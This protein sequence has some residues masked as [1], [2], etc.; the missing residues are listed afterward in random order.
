MRNPSPSAGN[1]PI[2]PVP[3]LS[4]RPSNDEHELVTLVESA[5]AGDPDAWTRLVQRFD[6]M[7]RQIA[8]SYRLAP[9]DVDDVVQTTWLNL[10]EAIERIREPTAIAGWLATATRRGA[11]RRKQAYVREQPTD[12]PELGDRP[13]DNQPETSLLERERRAVL[14][15]AVARLPSRHRRLLNVMLT[16]PTLEYRQV[17]ELLCMPIGSIGPIRARSL[18]RLERD[19]QLR[20]LSDRPVA[21]VV[22]AREPAARRPDVFL[23]PA[24]RE[25]GSA[26]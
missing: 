12:D 17:S 19:P 15:G 24:P 13:D 8:R 18:V 14:A 9:A 7:L 23:V 3:P 10:F 26:A 2:L 20:A 6:R 5:R 4:R 1:G 25:S 11:L 22:S 16:H 21:P